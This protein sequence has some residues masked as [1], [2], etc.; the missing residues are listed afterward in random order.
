MAGGSSTNRAGAARRYED[1]PLLASLAEFVV[2]RL[3]WVSRN[4]LAPAPM[5]VVDANYLTEEHELFPRGTPYVTIAAQSWEA[6]DAVRAVR[7]KCRQPTLDASRFPQNAV[8][9]KH[10][11][12]ALFKPFPCSVRVVFWLGF[13]LE[14]G[15]RVA[16]RSG[17][18]DIL[19]YRRSRSG[20]FMVR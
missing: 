19:R 14:E 11:F 2:D 5:S 17:D 8:W 3:P 6:A 4:D 15:R 18:V 20:A 9:K 16:V 13:R 7:Q 10:R 12:R 1:D